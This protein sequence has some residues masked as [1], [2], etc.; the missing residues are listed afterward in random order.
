MERYYRIFGKVVK[1]NT[2]NSKE[3][4]V[5]HEEL[6]LYP[7]LNT[8]KFDVSINYV[9]QIKIDSPISNNPSINYLTEESMVCKLGVT[10]VRF[11][12][13]DQQIK[14]IDFCIDSG[15]KFKTKIQK[16]KSMQYTSNLEAIGQIFHELVL[17]PMAFLF[18]DYSVIHS[19]GV[20][21][22]KNE[23]VLF[24]GTG[25]VGKTSLEM[26]L[27]LHHEC[28]FFNDDIAIIDSSGNCFPNFSYPKIYGYNLQGAAHL[29]KGIVDNLSF[30][31]RVHYALKSL[32]GM[33][34]VRRRVAPESFYGKV[35]NSTEK[36]SSFVLLFRSNV[37][38]ITLEP[39]SSE[40]IAKFNS[41][42][43]GSEYN[44]FFDQLRWHEF[45]SLSLNRESFITYSSTIEKNSINMKKGID[46]LENTY[47]AHIPLSISNNEYKIQMVE[48]LKEKAII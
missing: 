46:A 21:N 26:S 3:G 24:G 30:S 23:I 2:I 36:L 35:S 31:S 20:V 33:N 4:G 32:K 9:S 45:N 43:I 39:I 22:K 14:Q 8:T 27:C 48:K 44:V 42:I 1:L 37:K 15:T 11:Y 16:W 34:K 28:S 25:G 12:F 6:S 7:V 38:E 29:K 13:E 19:S 18:N 17:V 5:L 41:L 10:T 40:K 47:L